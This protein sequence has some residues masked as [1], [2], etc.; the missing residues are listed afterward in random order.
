MKEEL[1]PCPFCGG[2][3]RILVSDD[4]GNIHDDAYE[5]DPWSGLGYQ[6]A[7]GESDMIGECPIAKFDEDDAVMGINIYDSRGEAIESWNRRI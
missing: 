5:N 1:K 2:K 4:E 3:V 6:L 7:H